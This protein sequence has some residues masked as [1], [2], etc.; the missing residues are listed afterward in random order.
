MHLQRRIRLSFARFNNE[1]HF[2]M[3]SYNTIL[4]S[5]MNSFGSSSSWSPYAGAGQRSLYTS[6]GTYVANPINVNYAYQQGAI[7][8]AERNWVNNGRPGLR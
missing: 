7:T 5:T 4:K 2:A 3:T 6:S 1:V 8:A